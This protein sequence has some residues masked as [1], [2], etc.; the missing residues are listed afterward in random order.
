M[1]CTLKT[2]LDRKT[3]QIIY[4]S[5]IRPLIEYADVVWDKCPCL[6]TDQLDK[7]Q[8][9]AARIVTGCSKLVSLLDLSREAV[10]ESLSERRR[11][12]KL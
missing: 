11:K 5:F 8:T 3:L 7:I 6:L 10:W 4:F 9:E 12:H 2:R 1:M